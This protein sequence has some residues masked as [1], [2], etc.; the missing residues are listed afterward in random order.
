MSSSRVSSLRETLDRVE[1]LKHVSAKRFLAPSRQHRHPGFM[2]ISRGLCGFYF[3]YSSL[4]IARLY[5]E[6]LFLGQTRGSGHRKA[7]ASYLARLAKEKGCWRI[8]WAVLN[9]NEPA[10]GFYRKLGAIPMEEWAVYRLF[11][12]PLDQLAAE[13]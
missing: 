2:R 1:A 11:G 4:R 7:T 13:G 10:I 3:T 12:I 6:D 5:L 8:E 9:W